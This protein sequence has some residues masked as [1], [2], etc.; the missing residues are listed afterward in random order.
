[1]L[2]SCYLFFFC[3]ERATTDIYTD[4]HTLSLP[5]ARPIYRRRH[6]ED[7]VLREGEWRHARRTAFGTQPLELD[8]AKGS[9]FSVRF[10]RPSFTV[11]DLSG[12]RRTFRQDRKSKR[13][14]SSH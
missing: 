13:L 4:G 11:S 6:E 5:D 10:P 3:N 7:G 8:R 14:N 12:A 1:M 9:S 2:I